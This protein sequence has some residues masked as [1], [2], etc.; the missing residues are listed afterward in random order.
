MWASLVSLAS[1]LLLTCATELCTGCGVPEK[2]GNAAHARTSTLSNEE[3][4]HCT[5]DEPQNQKIMLETVG[6]LQR[7]MSAQKEGDSKDK[8]QLTLLTFFRQAATQAQEKVL[9]NY[10]GATLSRRCNH[11][12]WQQ[13]MVG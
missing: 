9:A 13:V 3:Q 8:P 6:T 5:I 7:E 11:E 2:V 4:D 10:H 1:K 12:R